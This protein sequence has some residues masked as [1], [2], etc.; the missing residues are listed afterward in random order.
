MKHLIITALLFLGS[1]ILLQAQVDFY[2]ESS[3]QNVPVKS[4]R[5]QLYA[6]IVDFNPDIEY[7]LAE[8]VE[9]DF[10]FIDKDKGR[11][12]FIHFN[13]GAVLPTWKWV[14][15]FDVGFHGGDL[16]TGNGMMGMSLGVGH[17]R[18]L[19]SN[20]RL[21]YRILGQYFLGLTY[22][23]GNRVSLLVTDESSTGFYLHDARMEYPD[24]PQI[25]TGV[26][27]GFPL[28]KKVDFN[29]NLDI[30]YNFLRPQ[31]FE[32]KTDLST[33]GELYYAYYVN[34][35]GGQIVYS[36]DEVTVYNENLEYSITK[37]GGLFFKIGFS[38]TFLVP[39]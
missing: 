21:G 33:G 24:F 27:Y 25:S 14:N 18:K 19:K 9:P 11:G 31:K 6:T 2:L 29:L 36:G 32:Y 17:T 15:T 3:F 16:T 22:S 39:K 5:S 34:Q 38:F 20:P 37:A 13:M 30:G 7:V 23:Y 8:F 10:E 4:E 35:G 1:S 26:S 28:S 12:Y